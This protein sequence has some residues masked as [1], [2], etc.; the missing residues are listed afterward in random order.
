MTSPKH[1]RIA[2]SDQEE[3]PSG[4]PYFAVFRPSALQDK[5][6][7]NADIRVLGAIACLSNRAPHNWPTTRDVAEF[8]GKRGAGS[9]VDSALKLEA[10]GHVRSVTR[11]GE[12]A[13]R[14]GVLLDTPISERR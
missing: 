2:P 11:P 12:D 7:S 1:S 5:A 13:L 8:L 4:S 3:T 6:I 10:C 9:V 14:W